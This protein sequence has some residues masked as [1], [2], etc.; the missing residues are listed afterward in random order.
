MAL[1]EACDMRDLMAQC[2]QYMINQST[3]NFWQQLAICSQSIKAQSLLRV[4][5]GVEMNKERLGTDISRSAALWRCSNCDLIDLGN[6][7]NCGRRRQRH[8][9][10]VPNSS[11]VTVTQLLEWRNDSETAP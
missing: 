11:Q 10:S 3:S 7:R 9:H 8:E 5:R 4:L 6:C 1:A 2:E